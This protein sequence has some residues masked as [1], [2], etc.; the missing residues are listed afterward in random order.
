MVQFSGTR[1][2][3]SA[4]LWV[5]LV[6]FAA[7][8]LYV[9]SQLVFISLSTQYGNF[10]IHP[11]TYVHIY[12]HA[13][14]RTHS[15][16]YR[17]H[18]STRLKFPTKLSAC[19]KSSCDVDWEQRNEPH[20]VGASISELCILQGAGGVCWCQSGQP[21][22]LVLLL[23]LPIHLLPFHF[24]IYISTSSSASP[25]PNAFF[26]YLCISYSPFRYFSSSACYSFPPVPYFF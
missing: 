21:L 14:T 24:F 26:L 22:I 23:L 11:R 15:A 1:C 16:S 20:A 18:I 25:R 19:I 17:R 2:S 6:S 10:W 3:C 12:I 4:T 7:I 5:S 13:H 9:P 8:T